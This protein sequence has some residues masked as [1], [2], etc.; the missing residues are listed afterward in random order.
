MICKHILELTF[1][2]KPEPFLK[3]LLNGLKYCYVTLTI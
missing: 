3:T 1:W 2:N